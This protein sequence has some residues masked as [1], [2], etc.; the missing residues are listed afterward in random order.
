M[1]PLPNYTRPPVRRALNLGELVSGVLVTLHASPASPADHQ[2]STRAR[3][4]KP[5]AHPCEP[6]TSPS[7]R[8]TSKEYFCPLCGYGYWSRREANACKRSHR[9]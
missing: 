9:T 5:C 2:R 6:C 1:S 4:W 8:A 7:R 3:G